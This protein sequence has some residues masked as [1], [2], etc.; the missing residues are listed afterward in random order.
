MI[1]IAVFSMIIAVGLQ[2]VGVRNLYSLKN[3]ILAAVFFSAFFVWNIHPAIVIIS[4]G[5]IETVY[6]NLIINYKLIK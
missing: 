2:L 3:L 4:A 5:I 6:Q 1:R